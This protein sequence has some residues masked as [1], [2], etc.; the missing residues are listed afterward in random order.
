[1]IRPVNGPAPAP[2]PGYP[3]E[4]RRAAV[5]LVGLLGF[6]TGFALAGMLVLSNQSGSPM[7]LVAIGFGLVSIAAVG[8]AVAKGG[9]TPMPRTPIWSPPT[10]R[11]LARSAG[12]PVGGY[13]FA[14][15]L[16]LAFGVIGNVVIPLAFGGR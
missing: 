16:L 6:V 8:F 3:L 11:L 9:N 7:W 4:R 2:D 12:A 5:I 15:Y 13:L 14:F 1:V 10:L